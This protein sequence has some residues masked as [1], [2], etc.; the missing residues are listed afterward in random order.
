MYRMVKQCWLVLVFAFICCLGSVAWAGDDA[1]LFHVL[2]KPVYRAAWDAMLKSEKNVPSWLTE[3]AE[4][5]A[6]PTSPCKD[7]VVN[8][9]E[10]M[11][12]SVCKAHEC[13]DNLF[14]VF[15]APG[16]KQAWGVLTTESERFFGKPDEL[17]RYALLDARRCE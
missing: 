16:G 9:V 12:H 14:I 8:E 13:G 10:Y 2:K 5:S 11:V 6:G 3:W 7:A 1:Y 17:M 4:K 15:F